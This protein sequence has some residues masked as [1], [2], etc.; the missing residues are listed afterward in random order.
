[1]PLVASSL[2]HALVCED[3]M[4]TLFDDRIQSVSQLY[5]LFCVFDIQP[6]S[7]LW[8]TLGLNLL[9]FVAMEPEYFAIVFGLDHAAGELPME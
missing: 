8:H 2:E 4:P 9:L 3:E 1:M 5:G 7:L 6:I